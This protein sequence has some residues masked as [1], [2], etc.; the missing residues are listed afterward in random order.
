MKKKYYRIQFASGEIQVEISAFCA[1][2]ARILAQ[3]DRI[4][5]GLDSQ[6]YAVFVLNE[7]SKT[8][9]FVS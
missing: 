2:D 1:S 8:W 6:I 9:E 5:A 3:A 7:N 4:K